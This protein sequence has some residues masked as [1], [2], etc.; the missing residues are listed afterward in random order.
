METAKRL[1]FDTTVY[2]AA[3]Q[4][5]VFSPAY[6]MLQDKL[7]RTHLASVVSAELLTG[8]TDRAACRAV[9]DFVRQ[10]HMV[11]R[12]VTPSASDWGTCR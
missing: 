8:A 10:A 9:L 7:P 11:R 5:G 6:R 4:A 12:I 3:I 1:V 2:I